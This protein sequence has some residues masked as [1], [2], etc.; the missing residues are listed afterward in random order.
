SSV[1]EGAVTTGSILVASDEFRFRA[2]AAALQMVQDKPLVG[3]GYLAYKELADV[4][5]D[6]VLGSPHNEW[7][8]I[9]AEEGVIVG[10]VGIAFL[11]A[12]GDR[13]STSLNSSH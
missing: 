4:F 5:G 11:V 12:N 10:L 7:L 3:Q 1:S 6:P 13:K 8:R 9:F 2:W